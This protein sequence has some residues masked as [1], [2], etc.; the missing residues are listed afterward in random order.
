M[1]TARQPRRCSICANVGHNIRTCPTYYVA[2]SRFHRRLRNISFEIS[3]FDSI[4]RTGVSMILFYQYIRTL[5]EWGLNE[6][7]Y[8]KFLIYKGIPISKLGDTIQ[9]RFQLVKYYYMPE[10]SDTEYNNE[11]YRQNQKYYDL[12]LEQRAVM[13][14]YIYAMIDP[15]TELFHSTVTPKPKPT[16]LLTLEECRHCECCICFNNEE[17]AQFD[18]KH[19][20]CKN[21][22]KELIDREKLSCPLCRHEI[23]HISVNTLDTY[24]LLYDV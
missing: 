14:R 24:N 23:K 8:K 13:K 5:L 9:T 21:C 20:V 18:C 10:E 15:I 19:E 6:V 22:T 11:Y 4:N 7:S 12:T 3:R 1:N 17:I 2:I 16:I